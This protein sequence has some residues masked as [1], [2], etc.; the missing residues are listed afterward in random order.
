M[1]IGKTDPLSIAKE[2][3]S[4]TDHISISESGEI[5]SVGRIKC[6]EPISFIPVKFGTAGAF[7]LEDA[8]LISLEGSPSSVQLY[9]DA[10]FNHIKSLIGGPKEVGSYWVSY[11]SYLTSLDGLPQKVCNFEISAVENL[12]MMKLVT[13]NCECELIILGEPN[14]T[15]AFLCSMNEIN[16]GIPMKKVLWDLH[17][18]MIAMGN[19]SNARW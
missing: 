11:C 3:F 1:H 18:K 13:L 8:R 12:P 16:Y 10:R 7:D 14:L 17:K 9:F 4:F 15:R 19:E 2:S 5:S 6:L